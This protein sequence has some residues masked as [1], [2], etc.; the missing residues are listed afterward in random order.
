MINNHSHSW[1]WGDWGK[2]DYNDLL[3]KPESKAYT[4]TTS[5]TSTSDQTITCWFRPGSVTIQAFFTTVDTEF[6]TSWTTLNIAW[7]DLITTCTF[8]GNQSRWSWTSIEAV[9]LDAN[10]K[11]FIWEFTDT[12]FTLTSISRNKDMTLNISVTA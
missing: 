10:N 12:W 2:I 9:Y 3:N 5:I 4:T 7:D 11:A 6:S 8:E 1:L